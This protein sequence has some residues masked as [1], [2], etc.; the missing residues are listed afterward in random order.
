MIFK[1]I[2]F[3]ILLS[4]AL[5]F[6]CAAFKFSKGSDRSISIN[7]NQRWLTNKVGHLQNSFRP[8]E[9]ILKSTSLSTDGINE[10]ANRISPSENLVAKLKGTCLY[11]VGMMGS[12]KSTIGKL[13]AEKLGY[14]FLGTDELAEY[15][16]AM[17]IT[18]FF[19]L[20]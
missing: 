10:N 20:V 9:V 15:M 1:P 7:V 5:G 12:G 2:I 14:G 6:Q 11:L 13:L 4:I 3:S 8:N 18:E 19:S 17:P 16:I